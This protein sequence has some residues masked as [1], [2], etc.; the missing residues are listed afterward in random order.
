MLVIGGLEMD[1]L[2]LMHMVS[3]AM[4]VVIFLLIIVDVSAIFR[5]CQNTDEIV[6]SLHDIYKLIWEESRK[7]KL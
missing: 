5:I 1:N 6:N 3:F 7:E 2:T 4:S